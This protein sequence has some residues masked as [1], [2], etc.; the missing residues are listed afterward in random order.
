MGH[1]DGCTKDFSS[2]LQ[3]GLQDE[4]RNI[5]IFFLRDPLEPYLELTLPPSKNG[6]FVQGLI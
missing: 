2:Q 4:Q 1:D 6:I 5:H 3:M